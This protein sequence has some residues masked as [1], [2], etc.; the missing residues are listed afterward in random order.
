MK[1]PTFEEKKA[2]E[3]DIRKHKKLIKF[4]TKD[5]T[6]ELL[7]QK[8]NKRQFF[9]PNYQRKFVW[10]EKNQSKFI[11]SVL[12]GLPI[13]FMFFAQCEDGKLEIIDGAQRI[14]SLDAFY[15][16]KLK[17]SGL[18]KLVK[19]NSFT[20]NDLSESEQLKFC[21]IPFRVIVL[22]EDTSNEVRQD[23]FHR[24]NTTGIRA[25]DSEIRRG[26]YP[27]KLTDFIE[28]CSED[29]LL[30]SL[31]PL[32]KAKVD[33]YEY[34]ELVLRFFA[35][36]YNYQNFKHS[37]KEFL[38]EFINKN[39]NEFDKNTYEN[40]FHN[41]LLFVQKTFPYGFKKTQ[42]TTSTP[43]VRFEALAVG[44]ALALKTNPNLKVTNINW[45]NSDEFKDL[46]TSDAS[47]NTNRLKDRIEFVKTKL[48]EQNICK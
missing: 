24:I 47:N 34:F 35:Y 6:I 36:L 20:Y 30:R 40:D 38:D 33:R 7:L 16:N 17:L 27:G 2:A 25:N 39:L 37:V 1:N 14:Q 15:N 26:S 4:D 41:M 23:L 31:C 9:I 46:T 48:L 45:I 44:S 43:R 32:P 19:L 12:L 22:D 29:Q 13:P 21:D 28:K 10:P 3:M 8:F 18:K 11:E 42:K 5:Y